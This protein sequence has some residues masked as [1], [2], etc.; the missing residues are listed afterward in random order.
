MWTAA[1]LLVVLAL[2]GGGAF[3]LRATK[4]SSP[5]HAQKSSPVRVAA[6]SPAR[7]EIV[8]GDSAT[9][10]NNTPT[11]EVQKKAVS[12]EPIHLATLQAFDEAPPEPEHETRHHRR[13]HRHWHY[14]RFR[15]YHRR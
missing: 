7:D 11:D 6:S 8:L 3:A 10:D 14:H 4:T 5:S 9:N 12:T 13:V 2:I 15:R 1:R